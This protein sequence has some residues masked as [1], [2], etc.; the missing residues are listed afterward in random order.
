MSIVEQKSN[1][2]KLLATENVTV[3]HKKVDTASFNPKTRVLTIPIWKKM[4]SEL[5]DLFLSHEVGHALWTPAE[6]WHDAVCDKGNNYK[7]FLNVIE[8]ARIEKKVK[9][10]YPGLQ[11]SYTKGFD[12]IMDK[13]LFGIQDIEEINGRPF[14]DRINIFTKGSY[15]LPI[16]FTDEEL[17]V[18]EEIKKLESW[19]DVVAMTERLYTQAK[20]ELEEQEVLM[21]MP[22]MMSNDDDEPEDFDDLEQGDTAFGSD[23]SDEDEDDS[24]E[25]IEGDS[26]GSA[27]SDYDDDSDED[28]D[29]EDSEKSKDFN[30]KHG[31][32]GGDEVIEPT[33]ETD[34]SFRNMEESLVDD[35]AKDNVYADIP[36]VFLKNV[37]EKPK[38]INARIT[39]HYNVLPDRSIYA[40][41][42]YMH[43]TE[44]HPFFNRK[45]LLTDFKKKN[46]RYIALMAKEFEMK[47]AATKYAKAR[48]YT[49]GDI[50]VNKIY[51]YKFDDQIFR[52]L[53][54]LPKGKK[55]GVIITLDMSGSMCDNMYG[56]LEQVCILTAFCKRVQIPFRVFGFTSMNMS[57]INRDG[58]TKDTVQFSHNINELE[59][60]D[61]HFKMKEFINSDMGAKEYK[62]AFE[63]LLLVKKSFDENTW[64]RGNNRQ[65]LAD[66]FTLG[67]TPL[68][69][70]IV[71]LGTIIPEFKM[72]NG[73]DIVNTIFIH[74]GDSNETRGV[75]HKLEEVTQPDGNK[76][77]HPMTKWYGNYD[78][79]L[80]LQDKKARFSV[81]LNRH[82]N[83]NETTALLMWLKAKTDAQVFGFFVS[84]KMADAIN[85]RYVNEEG[86][87][88]L[89][90]QESKEVKKLAR[91]QKFV[92]SFNKGFD[93]FFIL[94]DSNK[95][96]T[97]DED[98]FE[99]EVKN[100]KKINTRNLASQFVK[101]SNQKS[102]NRVLATQFVEKIAVKL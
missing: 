36:K 26:D 4:S 67:S 57:G 88:Y 90:W 72:R 69:H 22:G 63:N 68:N 10:K 98:E 102:V 11:R 74:D 41:R 99:F 100:E 25:E 96:N 21:K 94:N 71:A 47:K 86:S 70:S 3:Q 75:I 15:D 27:D 77:L 101:M 49:S 43:Q 92:Q 29:G 42:E 20:E 51:K 6:G 65:H 80:Y 7:S 14:I 13:N 62:N 58:E 85:Y 66:D 33:C 39:K 48:L 19:E 97:D 95:L 89:R 81:K 91:K 60:G 34:E 2:A 12:E 18:I 82:R 83:D 5:Y 78:A 38:E 40:N 61:Y 44:W 23:D 1:L 9:R 56:S 17:Q 16:E 76:K 35:D 28:D 37:I 8:D 93:S 87:N 52:K 46:D 54:K 64:G 31:C 30:S 59:M 53:T 73:L 79:N 24:N 32:T 50:D 84:T 45:N 55:H